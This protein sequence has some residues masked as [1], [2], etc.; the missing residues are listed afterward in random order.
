[1]KVSV[2]MI[3]YRHSL[4]IGQAIEGVLSQETNH[5]LELII[6]DD[7]SPDDTESIVNQLIVNNTSKIDIKYYRHA[8]N[9]GAM[10]NLLF[11]IKKCTGDFIAMCEG[12]DYWMDE[13]KLEKQIDFLSNHPD[14]SLSYTHSLFL[15]NSTGSLTD[16]GPRYPDLNQEGNTKKLLSSKFVEFAASVFPA[17]TLKVIIESIKDE[18]KDAI[19]GDTRI[20]L[21][22]SVLGDF[23]FIEQPMSVYRV[24]EDSASHSH[25]VDKFIRIKKDSLLCRKQFIQRNKLPR[26]W[27]QD[28][29]KGHNTSIINR[30]FYVR[31]KKDSTELMRETQ[32]NNFNDLF[33]LSSKVV[34]KYLLIK[35]RIHQLT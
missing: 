26:S 32:I 1:M 11:A 34:I 15:N 16:H 17:H 9:V 7:A 24:L 19:I 6:A 23:H 13:S 30:A 8:T 31:N 20:F 2:C 27:L 14:Y 5:E 21:E 10:E 3:T 12:D 22:A 25:K 4:Y 28:Y 33:Q 29:L 35:T 18:L